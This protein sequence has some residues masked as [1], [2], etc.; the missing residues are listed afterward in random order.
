MANISD[1]E[2]I[3]LDQGSSNEIIGSTG[4]SKEV[5][6]RFIRAMLEEENKEAQEAWK[7]SIAD[8]AL[9]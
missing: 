2:I 4:T 9:L 8:R 6:R 5:M 1:H 3:V 7:E